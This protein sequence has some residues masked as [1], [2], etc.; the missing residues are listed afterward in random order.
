VVNGTGCRWPATAY[1]AD[2]FGQ[3]VLLIA[4]PKWKVGNPHQLLTVFSPHQNDRRVR[5]EALLTKIQ[6]ADFRDGAPVPQ[7]RNP[8]TCLLPRILACVFFQSQVKAIARRRAI[9]DWSEQ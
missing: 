6:I 1:S 7:C 5:R 9:R 2:F 3:K 8:I 4:N